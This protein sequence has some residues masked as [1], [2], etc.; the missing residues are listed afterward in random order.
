MDIAA[1]LLQEME[2]RYAQ[3]KCG[4]E[5]PACNRCEDDRQTLAVINK[6]K[7]KQNEYH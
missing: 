2:Y 1:E 5:H 7:G 4:C 3:A 6:A